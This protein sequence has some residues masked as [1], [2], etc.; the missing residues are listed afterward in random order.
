MVVGASTSQSVHPSSHSLSE[1][2]KTKVIHSFTAW[3]SARI[4]DNDKIP[5]NSMVIP[6]GKALN[7][8]P[9]FLCGMHVV[10]QSSIPVVE[11]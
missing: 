7:M 11:A 9:L 8:I 4:K 10:R 5:A 3:R 6:L 1:F 2:K